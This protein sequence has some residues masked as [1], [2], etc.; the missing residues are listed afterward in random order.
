MSKPIK[1]WTLG[2]VQDYCRCHLCEH[3]ELRTKTSVCR[4][5]SK[6]PANWCLVEKRWT[7]AELEICRLLGAKWLVH[8][9]GSKHVLLTKRDKKREFNNNGRPYWWCGDED[10]GEIVMLS[11]DLFP[12]VN[13]EDDF[14][15]MV[16]TIISGTEKA[17]GNEA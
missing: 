16:G 14:C 13:L 17:G 10:E 12:S 9:R 4:V 6:F 15:V 8:D 5:R 7:H 3:C 11:I 2:E 1:D